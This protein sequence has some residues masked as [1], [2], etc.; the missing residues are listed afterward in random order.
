[1]VKGVVATGCTCSGAEY[2]AADQ[3]LVLQAEQL[4]TSPLLSATGSVLLATG[5][6][7]VFQAPPFC[8]ASSEIHQGICHLPCPQ[9][10]IGSMD[11]GNHKHRRYISL[12]TGGFLLLLFPQSITS[13]KPLP[14]TLSLHLDCSSAS[15]HIFTHLLMSN[16]L[17]PCCSLPRFRPILL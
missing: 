6:H 2:R 15:Y 10:L 14:A 1:M 7:Y 8:Q 17:W 16:L 4:P 5:S 11:P 12:A 13:P 9:V 3:T